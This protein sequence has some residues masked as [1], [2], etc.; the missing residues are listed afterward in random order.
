MPRDV[1]RGFE[2]K[3]WIF[4][5]G[6]YSFRT[7]NWMKNGFNGKG[8]LYVISGPSGAGKGTICREIV[9]DGGVELSIS[10]TTR[11][12]RAGELEGREYFFVSRE[13]FEEDIRNGNLL[14]YANVYGNMYGTPRDYVL[15][16]LDEG[17]DVILEIDI[18]GGL[19]VKKSMP[20]TVMIFMLPPS[21]EV[22]HKR[23]A[24]RNTDDTEVIEKRFN[25]AMNEIR[26]VGEYDYCIINDDLN[27][28]V[29]NARAIIRAKSLTVPNNIMPIIQKYEN[30]I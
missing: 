14:E 5:I 27:E 12:P 21:L 10:M 2:V 11:E 16:K 19:Q 25:E 13:R 6:A 23:L 4:G 1:V 29:N 17:R 8:G 30:G 20:E 26:L 9:K 7:E 22:L 24:G 18:Q 3:I 28:A 15:K